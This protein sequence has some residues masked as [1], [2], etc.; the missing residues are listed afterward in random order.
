MERETLWWNYISGAARYVHDTILEIGKGRVLL[1]EEVPFLEQYLQLVLE[2]VRQWDSSLLAETFM[3]EE[4]S[5]TVDVGEQ[6]MKRYAPAVHYHPM[7]GTRAKCIAQQNLLQGRV[8]I[9][10]RVESHKGWIDFAVEYAKMSGSRNGLLILTYA[11]DRPLAQARKGIGMLRWDQYITEY[12]MHLFASYCIA[13]RHDLSSALKSY[14]TNIAARLADRNPAL[15]S[16]FASERLARDPFSFVKA[17]AEDSEFLNDLVQ[18]PHRIKS[19]L[20]ESQIQTA[21]PIIENVRRRLIESYYDDLRNEL[22]QTDEFGKVLQGPEDMEMRHMWYYY[23]KTHGFRNAEDE[24]TFRLVYNARNKLA[25][26]DP[27]DSDVA[28]AIFSLTY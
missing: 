7:D 19:V 26:L 27:L 25:H 10:R 3:A 14:I 12:D 9:A 11:G 1:I 21:F 15:C 13:D 6:L 18:Q 23:F 20:W 4:W 28:L 2:R 24:S 8:I 17:L 5:G 16:L 22:P